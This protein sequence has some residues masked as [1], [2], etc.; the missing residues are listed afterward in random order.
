M[1]ISILNGRAVVNEVVP[2]HV[3]RPLRLQTQCRFFG[4]SYAAA[5]GLP[6]GKLERF[7][8][9]DALHVL[10]VYLPTFGEQPRRSKTA[11]CERTRVTQARFLERLVFSLKSFLQ[12]QL[13]EYQHRDR[14]LQSLVLALQILECL[15]LVKLQTAIVSAPP[16]RTLLRNVRASASGARP[17]R[18]PKGRGMNSNRLGRIL[19][20]SDDPVSQNI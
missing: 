3:A 8:P 20:N 9:P 11:S 6:L 18:P 17:Q 7:P 1:I 14:L 16:M 5:F 19:P 10:H 12:D 4:Q 13:G 15:R 2:P